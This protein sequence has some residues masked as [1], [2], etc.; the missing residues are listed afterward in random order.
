MKEIKLDQKPPLVSIT[1][2]CYNGEKFLQGTL[3]SLV[4]QNFKDIE[5]IVIDDG[6][7]DNS[8]K[9][10]EQFSFFRNLRYY[11]KE[12]GGTG[13]ALNLGH[14]LSRGK[15]LT[16]CSADNI[17][18]PTFVESFI[19]AFSSLEEH[20]APVE[21]IYSDFCYMNERGQIVSQVHHDK[22]QQPKDLC[23]GYDVGMSFM[24]TKNLWRKT[25]PYWNRICEDFNWAVRAAQHTKFGLIKAILAAFR[26]HG[27]QITGNK[28]VEEKQSADDC[29]AL[30]RHLFLGAEEPQKNPE[31][32][33]RHAPG[34]YNGEFLEVPEEFLTGSLPKGQS[35]IDAIQ[36]FRNNDLTSV[37]G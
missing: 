34:W 18:F 20:N 14:A 29:K 13:S 9:I 22:P 23:D 36:A 31:P 8:H 26:V 33:W 17:Y 37:S 4:T 24:Y 27:G 11:K 30:A 16:W 10:V 7:T 35:T 15:Y 5:I 19:K 3:N 28:Q 32:N 6:S 12:N 1:V 21:L 25:G 2:P